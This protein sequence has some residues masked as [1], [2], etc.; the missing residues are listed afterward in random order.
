MYVLVNGLP[1]FGKKI[2]QDLNEFDKQNK[3]IFLDT[4]YSRFDQ[5]LFFILV[6]FSRLFISFNGVSDNSG[7]LNWVLKWKKKMIMQW[8]GSDVMLAKERFIKKTIKIDY[9]N[10]ANHVTDFKF[11]QDELNEIGIHSEI[12]PY[13]HLEV[14]NELTNTFPKISILSYVGENNEE[15]YGIEEIISAAVFLKDV[16]FHLIGTNGLSY[17]QVPKNIIFHGWKSKQ[18]VQDL[19]KMCPIFIRMTKHDGNALS[20]AEALIM[21][22]EVIWTYPS[23]NT[24]LATNSTE[25]IDKIKS[26]K[27]MIEIRNMKPNFI[28]S[29]KISE[30]Y[31]RDIVIPNYIK[32]IKSIL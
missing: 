21:G 11:L 29:Q 27:S 17:T 12:L 14:R 30:Q 24:H 2:V 4:Y 28:I 16:D 1:L 31:N 10:R 9:I 3:Y 13:K 25:L 8:Q 15:L 19:M 32:Y 20:V 23:E 22:C 6:P 7:A 18:E 5:I 26:L